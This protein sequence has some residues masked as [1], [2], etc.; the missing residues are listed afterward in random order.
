MEMYFVNS[1]N[2]ERVGFEDGTLVIWFHK[3][4]VYEYH[5]VPEFV[6]HDLLTASSA[7]SYVHQH[8]VGRYP[9]RKIR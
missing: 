9:T 1:S 2:V 4:G 5:N 6:F 7:G 8:I 3:G